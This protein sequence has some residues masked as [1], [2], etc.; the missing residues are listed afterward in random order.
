MKFF[1]NKHIKEIRNDFRSNDINFSFSEK[2]L[3]AM[4][5]YLYANKNNINCPKIIID[6]LPVQFRKTMLEQ[7]NFL[8]S[9]Y[10][11]EYVLDSA[12]L[13]ITAS[14]DVILNLIDVKDPVEIITH[15]F[16][17][18]E[19]NCNYD[20][21]K[22][23][24]K[25]NSFTPLY[26]AFYNELL[27][28]INKWY[29]NQYFLKS[30]DLKIPS[31]ALEVASIFNN[32]MLETKENQY[33]FFNSLIDK[34]VNLSKIVDELGSSQFSNQS[35]SSQRE[36]IMNIFKKH[37]K[38]GSSKLDVLCALFID[39]KHYEGSSKDRVP[40]DIPV[41]IGVLYYLMKKNLEKENISS[42]N[43]ALFSPSPFFIKKLMM[44]PDLY[45][46]ECTIVVE[47][48]FNKNILESHFK[49]L[50]VS[51]F[52]LCLYEDYFNLDDIDRRHDCSI[53]FENN[54]KLK[55]NAELILNSF[56]DS[57]YGS[58]YV[59]C[60]EE[61][62]Y[63]SIRK[64]D[65]PIRDI[66]ILPRGIKYSTSPKQKVIMTMT[67][68]VS[69]LIQIGGGDFNKD[70][71]E[72]LVSD[73]KV[74]SVQ[75]CELRSL[76]SVRKY[77]YENTFEDN[78]TIGKKEPLYYDFSPEIRIWYEKQGHAGT[79]KSRIVPYICEKD[80]TGKADR[81]FMDRGKKIKL[82]EKRKEPIAD[83]DIEDWLKNKYLYSSYNSSKLGR[84]VY[85]RDEIIN[86]IKGNIEDEDISIRTLVYVYPELENMMSKRD[87]VTLKEMSYD[88]IGEL[89][90]GSSD[91]E[92]FTEN[93]E[94]YDNPTRCLNILYNLI[95]FAI[96]KNHAKENILDV[97]F[98]Q[99]ITSRRRFNEVR[100]ALTKKSFTQSEIKTL[101]E[102][103][104]KRI[105][106]GNFKYVGVLLKLYTGIDSNTLCALKWDDIEYIHNYDIFTLH[107]YKQMTNDGLE[108]REFVKKESYRKI[109]CSNRLAWILDVIREKKESDG[110][111]IGDKNII[112]ISPKAFDTLCSD[113]LKK[114][115]IPEQ[116]IILPD[117]AK[118]TKETNLNRYNGDIFRTNFRYWANRN[119]KLSGDEVQYILGN[120]PITT[121]GIHYCDFVN[122]MSQMIL[123]VK[124]SRLDNLFAEESYAKFTRDKDGKLIMV[125]SNGMYP[126]E[127]DIEIPGSDNED[128][129]I[130]IKNK[131]G[132]NIT[133]ER[134]K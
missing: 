78:K 29:L 46:L 100:A 115:E 21:Y 118:G 104:V 13:Y 33:K 34:K 106:S 89:Y 23:L 45:N 125:K 52:S 49:S 113:L 38:G 99:L 32:E 19:S 36:S 50:G 44:D 116:C 35:D 67:D 11:F 10:S 59:L 124:I 107:I 7:Y 109:P 128:R 85:I 53:L 26:D 69:P 123:Q 117:F 134:I 81:G 30:N 126:A 6:N 5:G 121:F 91:L 76:E 72:I 15:L 101:E 61:M 95:N 27:L 22:T 108:Y 16:C 88:R 43:I 41:E 39:K 131:Y 87:Y 60:S 75:K 83:I 114:L 24:A 98:E 102:L 3:F 74:T 20:S 64:Y 47:N 119:M 86:A 103:A 84:R 14:S 77:I 4:F 62:L 28:V 1:E 71:Q 54:I 66:F 97:E 42:Q 132:F 17:I 73:V 105:M 70:K 9:G 120:K 94:Y 93:V 40:N 37:A 111:D 57:F 56:S 2:E 68:D 25:A 65:I 12:S 82:T 63:K 80:T 129:L 122:D 110:S 92:S 79:G 51:S 90:V 18:D 58:T 31:N 96:S 8:I 133:A 130:F 48:E 127:L 112:D 55:K